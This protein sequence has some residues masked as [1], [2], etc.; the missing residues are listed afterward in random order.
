VAPTALTIIGSLIDN[1][2]DKRSPA[3]TKR[4]GT[5]G[6]DK[7][8]TAVRA[9]EALSDAVSLL[10]ADAEALLIGGGTTTVPHINRGTPYSIAVSLR[11]VQGGLDAVAVAAD[12][13]LVTVGALAPLARLEREPRLAFLHAALATVG[14]PTLRSTATV[15]GNFFVEEP[16]GDVA[17]ALIALGA[18]GT[19]VGPDGEEI[20]SAES[21]AADGLSRGRILTSLS[22]RLPPAGA[23][24]FRKAARRALNS[25]SIVTVA[26]VVTEADG[27]VATA[28]VAL[29]G[30][31]RRPKRSPAAEAALIGRPLDRATAEAAG[32]AA[33]ADADPFDDEYASAWYRARVLPVHVRRALIGD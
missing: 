5:G 23:W 28:R 4:A 1:R 24:H 2:I 8:L 13:D 29:S 3:A 27:V 7:M 12:G 9:P 16:Y 31:T 25:A 6:N 26:A 18:T 15:G 22:F 20:V 19:V 30:A 32:R 10:S 21:L 33:L 17:C 11:R 14:S